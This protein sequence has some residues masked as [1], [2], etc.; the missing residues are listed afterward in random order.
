MIAERFDTV[1]VEVLLAK[2]RIHTEPYDIE[3]RGIPLQIDPQVFNP[4][5]TRVTNF[6]ADY[7][8]VNQGEELLD[9]FTGSGVLALLFVKN[10]A[11]VTGVDISPY[12]VECARKNAIRLGIAGKAEFLHGRLWQPVANRKFDVITANPP[13]LPAIPE[14]MLE[15]AVADSLDMSVTTSFI[16]G[17]REHLADNG[18]VYMAFSNA[19]KVIWEDPVRK[20]TEVALNSDLEARIAAEIDVGYEIYRVMEFTPKRGRSA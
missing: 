13:L 12:A 14:N 3:F 9:M 1:P 7:I 10:A 20:V 15:T 5:Y 19:C 2:H 6:I 18:R 16:R 8:V 11:R 17:C 4:F